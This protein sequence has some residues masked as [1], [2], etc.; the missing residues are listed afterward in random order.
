M[1]IA[2]CLLSSVGLLADVAMGFFWRRHLN[3]QRAHVPTLADVVFIHVLSNHQ[4]FVAMRSCAMLLFF[5]LGKHHAL[6]SPHRAQI[7]DLAV[8]TPLSDQ[9][10]AGMAAC[11]TECVA[12]LMALPC[13]KPAVVSLVK[14]H[15]APTQAAMIAHEIVRRQFTGAIYMAILDFDE[16]WDICCVTKR[17][18]SGFARACATRRLWGTG[19]GNAS[20]LILLSRGRL[21]WAPTPAELCALRNPHAGVPAQG[22]VPW[23]EVVLVHISGDTPVTSANAAIAAIRTLNPRAR[24]EITVS[25]EHDDDVCVACVVGS[26]LSHIIDG[27]VKFESLLK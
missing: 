18:E 24:P 27:P 14:G 17:P 12:K 15:V 13:N 2:G 4:D 23:G 21:D 7:A 26:D 9:S 25:F 8:A 5:H 6:P 10:H 11:A 3:D 19:Q 22:E 1:D 20:L 16:S